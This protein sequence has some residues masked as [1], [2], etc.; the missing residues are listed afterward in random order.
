MFINIER[1]VKTSSRM[2]IIRITLS[3]LTRWFWDN[4]HL[5]LFKC[6]IFIKVFQSM[7]KSLQTIR[8]YLYSNAKKY[9]FTLGQI[10]I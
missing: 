6:K 2:L 4:N 1:N 10:L 9:K 8:N 7:L 5:Q 3:V